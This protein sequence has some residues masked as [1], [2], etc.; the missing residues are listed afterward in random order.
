MIKKIS[1]HICAVRFVSY[2]SRTK[3]CSPYCVNASERISWNKYSKKNR[4]ERRL[5]SRDRYLAN[6]DNVLKRTK[7]N[8]NTDKGRAALNKR[9]VNNR[10]KHRSKYLTRQ[11][12]K[13][14]VGAGDIIKKPC[15]VCGE[16]KVQAHHEDYINHLNVMWLCK[17]HHHE[18]HR[19][20]RRLDLLKEIKNIKNETAADQLGLE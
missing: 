9:S 17:D 6:K 4:L 3:Y 19:K 5:H 11:K 12:T 8:Q 18:L 7:K 14:A 1:C 16:V 20:T 15:E 13:M 10:V 2:H